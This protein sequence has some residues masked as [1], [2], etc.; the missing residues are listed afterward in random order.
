MAVPNLGQ[1]YYA[2]L[3][4][5]EKT[6]LHPLRFLHF[7]ALAYV[8]LSLKEPHRTRLLTGGAHVI[9]RVSQQSLAVF[10]ASLVTAR[11]AS[12][13]FQLFGTHAW[14]T[15]AVNLTGVAVVIGV[16]GIAR[17]FRSAPWQ[18]PQSEREASAAPV[19]LSGS[20]ANPA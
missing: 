11:A 1:L 12:V 16:A 7:L 13:A 8:A 18:K 17:W 14:V 2:L 5:T 3:P 19:Y 15:W 6:D 10:L 4:A 9:I 20:K